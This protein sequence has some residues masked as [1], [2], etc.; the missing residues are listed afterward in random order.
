M[1]LDVQ[2]PVDSRTGV[3]LSM[4]YEIAALLPTGEQC[5]GKGVATLLTITSTR[6][7]RLFLSNLDSYEG[8]RL[9]VNYSVSN[10]S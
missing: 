4:S 7:W 1:V 2:V 3:T 5:D 8:T 10:N 9:F 6:V